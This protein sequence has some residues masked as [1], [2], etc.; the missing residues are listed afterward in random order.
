MMLYTY[1]L[2][3]FPYQVS[4]SY[5]I[6]LTAAR[7]N[8]KSRPH[9]DAAHLHSPTNVPTKCQ[10]FTP[11]GFQDIAWIRFSNSSSLQEGPM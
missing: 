10:P 4:T 9:L 1:T 6:Q 8:I 7:Y 11:Y 2:Q 3:Q 5:T